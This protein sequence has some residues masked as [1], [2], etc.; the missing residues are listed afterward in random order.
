MKQCYNAIGSLVYKCCTAPAS[1]NSQESV[2]LLLCPFVDTELVTK[3]KENFF[4]IQRVSQSV[5]PKPLVEDIEKLS[6]L[7]ESFNLL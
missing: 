5:Q 2:M 6:G 7:G 3:R 1:P 4:L